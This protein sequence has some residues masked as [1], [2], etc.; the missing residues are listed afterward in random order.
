MVLQYNSFGELRD[1]KPFGTDQLPCI[2]TQEDAIKFQSF[3]LNLIKKC[4][5]ADLQA[6]T[7]YF[8]DVY[9][10]NSDSN[11]M[12]VFT[13]YGSSAYY[14]RFHRNGYTSTSMAFRSTPPLTVPY[15]N[16]TSS[17]PPQISTTSTSDVINL[18][19]TAPFIVFNVAILFV[20]VVNFYKYMKY[21]P[22]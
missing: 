8:Y 13:N 18:T 7:P 5:A 6:S 12:E 2:A 10:I 11:Y 9:V 4:S 16:L 22:D 1:I 3:G 17:D 19:L 15:L 20:F 14:K 21:N